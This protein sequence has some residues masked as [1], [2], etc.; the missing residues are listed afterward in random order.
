MTVKAILMRK[1]G[2]VATIAASATLKEAVQLLAERRIGA[3]IVA[4]ADNR[5]AGM[6]SERDIV[7]MLARD[8]AAALDTQVEHTMTRKV[9]TCGQNDTVG[10]IMERMTAGRFRHLP[11]VEQERLVGVIS[12]GDVVKWR[13]EEMEQEQNAMREYIATA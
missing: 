1:G 9:V 4:G 11:V 12:I 7:R 6:L 5:V 2:D 13:L 3:V 10:M 8:G